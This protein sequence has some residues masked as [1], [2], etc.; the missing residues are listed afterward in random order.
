MYFFEDVIEEIE[1]NIL[2]DIDIDVLAKKSNMSVYEFRRIFS[3]LAKIPVSEYIRKRRLSLA[4]L[5]MIEKKSSVTEIALKYGYDSASSF[6]RAFKEF[7]GVVPSEINEAKTKF[8]MIS[9]IKNEI[10]TSGGTLI[11]YKVFKKEEFT[12]S[13]VSFESQLSDTECCEDAWNAFYTDEKSSDLINNNE[14]IFVVY[15]NDDDSVRCFFGNKDFCCEEKLT[16]PASFW[17]S[18]TVNNTDDEYINQIYNKILGEW[19]ISSG[20]KRN[21]ALPNIEV[22]PSDMSD[23]NFSWEIWIPIIKER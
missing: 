15:T 13:G 1:K 17:V 11:D 20:Y 9:K 14:N 2:N 12:L 16:V 5:E 8:K 22:F 18:L 3:F 6:S 19:L 7:H 4:A 21:P 10:I 23:E